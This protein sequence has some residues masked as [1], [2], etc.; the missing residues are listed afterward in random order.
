MSVN[1]AQQTDQLMALLRLR[2]QLCAMISFEAST[3][4]GWQWLLCY[5][6]ACKPSLIVFFV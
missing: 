2:L 3:R 5:W 4:A 1:Q 6:P